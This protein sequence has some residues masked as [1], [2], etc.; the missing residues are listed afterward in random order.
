LDGAQ[1]IPV[2][3]TGSFGLLDWAVLAAYMGVVIALG[4]RAGRR[5]RTGDDFFLGGRTMPVWAVALSV[6]ATSQ[7]AAT[8]VGGPQQAYVGNLTYLAAN[9]GALIAVLIVAA[10]FIPAYYRHGVT[11]VY[12]LIGHHYGSTSQRCASAMFMIGR[13]FASG[14]RLFI[15]AIPFALVTFGSTSPT[16]LLAAVALIAV[17][18]TAYTVVG[19]IRAVIWTDVLQALVYITTIVIALALLWNRIPL[20]LDEIAAQLRTAEGGSKLTFLETS[21]DLGEP[22]SIW[23]IVLGLTLFNL[24][25]FGADQDLTQRMLTCRTA[26][27]GGWSVILATLIGWPV[28]LAFLA[29]GLLLFIFYQRP[30]AMGD[31]APLYAVGDTRKVFLEFILHEMPTGVRGL[32]MAGLFAA[33]MSSMDSALN[34]MASTTIADF[35]RP[36]RARRPA[37]GDAAARELR[38][39]R[40]AIAAWAVALAGFAAFCIHWQAMSGQT[41]I[42]FALGI[43]VFAYAGLLA[44]FVTALFTKRGN[45]ISAGAALATGFVCVLLMQP[46]AWSRWAPA[47]GIDFTLAFPWKMLVATMIAFGVCCL[48]ARPGAHAT[49]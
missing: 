19:G 21:A 7:S 3:P 5:E 28:V 12:E 40:I 43:M 46:F 34:A 23:A 42:N 16:A 14:A 45:A 41:L 48:G 13:V 31:A 47:V 30:E 18:A 10:F 49:R 8:F 35:Y 4:I 27:G 39:S 36:W 33:A 17:G 25:A 44:V 38:A 32:M 6:L 24:A 37:Q 11:S 2:A 29:L 20:G 9:I 15:V 1:Q 26:R 22:F